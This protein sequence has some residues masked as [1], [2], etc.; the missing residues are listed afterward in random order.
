MNSIVGQRLPESREA[1]GTLKFVKRWKI[2]A[3]TPLECVLTVIG[4]KARVFDYKYNWWQRVW[5]KYW[6]Q[7]GLWTVSK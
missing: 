5:Y 2:M 3:G 1:S 7:R 6:W 4:D